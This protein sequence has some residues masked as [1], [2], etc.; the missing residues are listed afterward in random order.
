MRLRSRTTSAVAL[1]LLASGLASCGGDTDSPVAGEVDPVPLDLAAPTYALAT[2]DGLALRSGEARS[3]FADYTSA[4]WL[5]GGRALLGRGWSKRG[6]W[7]PATG[8]VTPVRLGDPNRS[9]TQISLVEPAHPKGDDPFQ[10]VAY[11]LDGDEQWRVNLPEAEVAPEDSED[12]ERMYKSAHTIDGATFLYWYDNS[13]LE[14]YDDYGILRVGPEGEDIK[15]VLEDV[16]VI[17]LWLAADG[18]SLLATRRVSGDPCGGCQVTQQ[19]VE[20]DPKDGTALATYDLP[21]AYDENWDVREVDKVGARI[22]VRF[23][24]TEF[25][26]PGTRGPWQWLE[27]RGTWVLDEDGWTMVEDSDEEVSWWQGAADRIVAVPL[28]RKGGGRIPGHDFAY[29]WEHDGERTRLRGLTQLDA[30][31]RYYE[32]SIPGQLLAPE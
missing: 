30:G 17:A 24:E 12:V 2:R 25:P 14:E 8:D 31:R 20:I 10:L 5:P 9:V 11:D 27:Q 23:E 13:E 32:A 16:P 21:E 3:T 26:E 1:V 28:E 29:W 6:I 7:D 22:A 19:L 18:S 15:Q 4:E